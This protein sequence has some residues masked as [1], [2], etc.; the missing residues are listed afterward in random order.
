MIVEI[1]IAADEP[2]YC[3]VFSRKNLTIEK[4]VRIMGL[5]R[6]PEI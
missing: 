6:V 3:Q 1:A 2:V 4:E 5:R